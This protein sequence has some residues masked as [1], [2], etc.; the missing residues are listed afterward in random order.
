MSREKEDSSA[1]PTL[2]LARNGGAGHK[3]K[4]RLAHGLLL[5]ED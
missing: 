4:H 3:A 5:F 1:L 2:G